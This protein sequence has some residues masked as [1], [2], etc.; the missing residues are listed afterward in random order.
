MVVSSWRDAATSTL[1]YLDINQYIE[2]PE[3]GCYHDKKWIEI[4]AEKVEEVTDR[5]FGIGGKQGWYY[6]DTLWRFRGWIDKMFLGV[7]LQRGRKSDVDLNPGDALDF[8]R[9]LVADRKNHRLLLFAEITRRGMAGIFNSKNSRK[10]Y[11]KANCH[12]SSTQYY[13][14]QLLVFHVAVSLFHFQKYD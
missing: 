9:V 6:A 14:T 8:W 5:F 10:T 11:S 1:Q 4:P 3:Y 13:G 2:V 7:G 12:F